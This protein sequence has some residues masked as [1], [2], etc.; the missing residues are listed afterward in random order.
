MSDP[1]SPATFVA[2]ATH[3][4]ERLDVVLASLLGV[5]RARA[6]AHL[7]AGD[8]EVDGRAGRRSQRVALGETIVVAGA[9][10]EPEPEAPPLPPV[11]WRDGH[12][13]VVAKPAGLVVHAGHGHPSGTLVDALRGAGIPLAPDAAAPDL[14]RPGIVHRL[15][16]DT[17]GLLA[18]ASTPAAH[19]GL[20]EALRRRAVVRRYLAVVVGVPANP[21][22]RIEAPIGRDPRDRTRFTVHEDGK[23]AT[24]RY[25][26]VA[27][28]MAGEQPVSLLACRLE[29]GRTHQIR[30]HLS[31]IGHAVVGDPTYGSRR[32]VAATLGLSRPFLHAARLAFDHPVTGERVDVIEPLPAE[33]MAALAAAGIATPDLPSVLGD[34]AEP[35]GPEG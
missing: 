3:V 1:A 33:L 34:A 21:V 11:R 9:A 12:L 29:T 13:L 32:S 24:T 31:A 26:L 27:S 35:P 16:R 18:V 25:A 14:R 22:G 8:V 23:A 15:D 6:A 4:G 20:I 5:S 17:S 7:D 2:D 19:A 30:V 28:G 10:P